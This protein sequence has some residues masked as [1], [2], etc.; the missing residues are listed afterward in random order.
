MKAT[1]ANNIILFQRA[2]QISVLA[3]AGY[4]ELPDYQLSN[5]EVPMLQGSTNFY[6]ILVLKHKARRELQG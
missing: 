3:N 5:H 4:N 2:F 6:R 1:E